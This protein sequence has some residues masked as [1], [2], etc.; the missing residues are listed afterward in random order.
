[1]QRSRRLWEGCKIRAKYSDIWISPWICNCI[2]YSRAYLYVSINWAPQQS[3][4]DNYFKN[5]YKRE[6]L[7]W[8]LKLH[9]HMT[10][11][12][13]QKHSKSFYVCWIQM[14]DV[15]FFLLF[16]FLFWSDSLIPVL[17]D[18]SFVGGNHRR[19]YGCIWHRI[20]LCHSEDQ[21]P[22]YGH[23]FH[24]L[25]GYVFNLYPRPLFIYFIQKLSAGKCNVHCNSKRFI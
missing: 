9:W 18:F 7:Q 17:F 3:I 10:H 5:K 19:L 12:I 4:S 14:V 15:W 13:L 21:L 22:Q 20:F 1:M 11:H 2:A 24:N 23:C 8:R 25:S 16:A 6:S